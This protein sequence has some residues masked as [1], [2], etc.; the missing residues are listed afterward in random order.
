MKKE[1]ELATIYWN[2]LEFPSSGKLST[3]FGDQ[4]RLDISGMNTSR[5]IQLFYIMA[6]ENVHHKLL[7]D[8]IAD[9]LMRLINFNKLK[10]R[11][12]FPIPHISHQLNEKNNFGIIEILV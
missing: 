3:E 9:Q 8:H 4:F 5:I 12:R 7:L 10:Y 1:E 6:K 2:S 11:P